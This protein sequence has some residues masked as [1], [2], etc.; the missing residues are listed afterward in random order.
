MHFFYLLFLCTVDKAVSEKRAR[1]RTWKA[2][3]SRTDYNRAKKLAR[4]AVY[5]ALKN[6]DHDEYLRAERNKDE[7]LPKS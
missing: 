5:T 6:D 3:G 1:W 4:R 2:G 7:I